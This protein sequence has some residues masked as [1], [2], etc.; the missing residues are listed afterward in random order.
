MTAPSMPDAAPASDLR[1]T[2]A[3]CSTGIVL[4]V[5]A[6]YSHGLGGAFLFDDLD[7]IV[8][9][10]TIRHLGGALFPPGGATVSG[11]PLLNLSFALNYAVSGTAPWSYH[12][13]NL[14]IHAAAA[15]VL[16]GI[17]R[18][19]LEFPAAGSRPPMEGVAVAFAVSLLWA[20]HP[21]QTESVAY[22][23]QRA[24]SLMGLLYL[25]TLYAFIR[26]AQGGTTAWA[27]ASFA[28]CLLG[29]AT[30]EVMATAPLVVFL[31]DRCFAAGSFREAWARRGALHLSLAACWVPLAVLVAH[32][33]G[34][35]GTA[36]FASGVPWWTYLLAQMQAIPHY[37]RLAAWP[38]PLVGDYGR[39]LAGSPLAVAAGACLVA[40]LAAGTW[41]LL[42]RRPAL[43]FLG[44]WLLVVLAPSSSFV[45][46]ATEIVAEHRMYLPLAAL[47]ALAA[48]GLQAWLGAT[49]L[50]LACVF[51]VAA[52]LGALTAARVRVYAGPVAFW[53]DVASKVPGNAGAWNN[54][55]VIL[56]ARGEHQAATAYFRRALERAPAYATAHFNLGK[57]LSAT[58]HAAD[59]AVEFREALRALPGDPSV[60]RGLGNALAL[61]GRAAAAAAEYREAIR[62]DPGRAD[63]WFDLGEAMVDLGDLP[64]ASEAYASAVRLSPGYAEARVSLANV[65]VQL[66]RGDDAVEAY[67]AALRLEPG[68]ADV[69]NNLGS[70]YAGMGR[71]TEARAE[72]E[73]ALQLRPDYADARDN[74]ARLGAL[75]AGRGRP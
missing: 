74:L 19:T 43:G 58:G 40:A 6:A 13:L 22:V 75:E 33:Q 61:Q 7:S 25:L 46:V 10:P 3:L 72:F 49:R 24:E 23:V 48:L 4:A 8:G 71:F 39:T 70:L 64:R 29:V 36:G 38:S 31:Y 52:L 32:T 1:S 2:L 60:H 50:F 41:L 11:R 28:S 67:R 15:L 26:F 34:R 5:A 55:G 47:A 53:S 37:L 63:A 14:A 18:R 42:V 20:L 51:L 69:H 9:N 54:L 17:V 57:S 66:G 62:L 44:A 65:L 68:A 56:A 21:L 12:A 35:A 73:K 16:F 45:P 27:Y 30:K 59:A